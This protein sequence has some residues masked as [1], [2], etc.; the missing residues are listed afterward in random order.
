GD[1]NFCSYYKN[2]DEMTERFTHFLEKARQ[3]VAQLP[4]VRFHQMVNQALLGI[5]LADEK[6]RSQKEVRVMAKQ[7]IR[8]G[9]GSTFFF[10][11]NGLVMA[12]LR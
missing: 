7:L 3:S 1:L 5:Y 4:H 8:L 9:G 11:I 6:V 12:R 2:K 10:F